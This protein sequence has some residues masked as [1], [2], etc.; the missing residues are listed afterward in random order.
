MEDGVFLEDFNDA[1][2]KL[3]G[4][5]DFQSKGAFI[6]SNRK[7]VAESM[8]R[9]KDAPEGYEDAYQALKAY[10]DA[11][12]RLTNLALNSAGYTYSDFNSELGDLNRELDT[13]YLT[14]AT[15]VG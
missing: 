8:S 2:G 10:Y 6:D 5:S 1:L 9:L 7:S 14:I 12:I 4:D 15:Y 13:C 11:Y 3:Y